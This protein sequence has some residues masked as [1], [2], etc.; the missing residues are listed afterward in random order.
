MKINHTVA[1]YV[2]GGAALAL[3]GF[4]SVHTKAPEL[5]P[6]AM[7]ETVRAS[8]FDWPGLGQ[9]KTIALGDAMKDLP[10]GKVTIFCSRLS[11]HE[12]RLDLDDAFQLAEW[13]TEFED[14]AVESEAN[15]GLFVGPPGKGAD[16]L[17]AALKVAT[18][19]EPKIVPIDGIEGVGII[20]G[21]KDQ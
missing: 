5:I 6:A 12:L 2:I 21:K 17:A 10:P 15:T 1:H 14:G 13:T 3:A 8:R 19:V 11:C 16:V 7:H 18:G 20:I 4:A 9:D